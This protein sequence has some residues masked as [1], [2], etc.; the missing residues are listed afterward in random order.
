MI[1]T[2]KNKLILNDKKYHIRNTKK[3]YQ[4]IYCFHFLKTANVF[5]I[6]EID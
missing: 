2:F 6:T 3:I 4:K 1:P 5:L